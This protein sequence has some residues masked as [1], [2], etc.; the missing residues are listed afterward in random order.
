MFARAL[1][2]CI[3]YSNSVTMSLMKEEYHVCTLC[4]WRRQCIQGSED[5]TDAPHVACDSACPKVLQGLHTVPSQVWLRII[6]TKRLCLPNLPTVRGGRT[7]LSIP[8]RCNLDVE[9]ADCHYLYDGCWKAPNETVIG[10]H[11]T[12][13]ESLVG[14][15]P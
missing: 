11:N 2:W 9:A 5:R 4:A 8:L 6:G 1:S 12:K 13:L 14:G 15:K 3:V 10:F 7:W